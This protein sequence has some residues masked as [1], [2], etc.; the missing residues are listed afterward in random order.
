MPEALFNDDELILQYE[1]EPD[2]QRDRLT[3]DPRTGLPLVSVPDSHM[4]IFGD[5]EDA[6]MHYFS[7]AYHLDQTGSREFCVVIITDE[8]F[9]VSVVVSDPMKKVIKRCFPIAHIER[10]LYTDEGFIGMVIPYD[11]DCLI[12]VKKLQTEEHGDEVTHILKV[13]TTIH[14]YRTSGTKREVLAPYKI[15]SAQVIPANPE[16]L[17]LDE[18]PGWKLNIGPFRTRKAL[19]DSVIAR[20]RLL[21]M[22]RRRINE[23]GREILNS[24]LQALQ[25]TMASD[26]HAHVS[27]ELDNLHA[28]LLKAQSERD[29][30][31]DKLR[32]VQH[33]GPRDDRER[34]DRDRGSRSSRRRQDS[35]RSSLS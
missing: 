15:D 25:A 28:H 14:K 30:Y 13:L 31:K 11:Y 7:D 32:R 8:F 4:P 18:P 12:Q 5:I 33:K 21:N 6:V 2:F 3:H 20:T 26:L 29:E 17:K 22:E 1:P 10:L 9:Y 23:Q 35:R 19:E 27:Q 34:D 24:R 16:I